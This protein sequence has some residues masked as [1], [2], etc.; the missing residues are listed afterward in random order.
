MHGPAVPVAGRA[1]R[2]S[3]LIGFLDDATRL[4]PHAAFAHAEWVF[5]RKPTTDSAVNRPP[6]PAQTDH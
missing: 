2:K 5:R 3:Y 4:V 1:R 6:I